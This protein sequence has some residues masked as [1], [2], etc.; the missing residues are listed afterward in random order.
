MHFRHLG[1][2]P[3]QSRPPSRL[4]RVVPVGEARGR[5][6]GEGRLREGRSLSLRV[7]PSPTP[8]PTPQAPQVPDERGRGSRVGEGTPTLCR[9]AQGGGP[10]PA[11]GGG[12]GSRRL[13][14]LSP[15]GPSMC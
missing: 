1:S 13:R 15:Q 8:G 3:L 2:A 12:R 11:P 5:G 9:G 14:P 7:S 6:T 4:P 10:L